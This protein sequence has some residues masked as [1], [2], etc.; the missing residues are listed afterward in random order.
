[1]VGCMMLQYDVHLGRM[2][3]ELETGHLWW[4][5]TVRPWRLPWEADSITTI[6]LFVLLCLSATKPLFPIPAESETSPTLSEFDSVQV[7]SVQDKSVSIRDRLDSMMHKSVDTDLINRD[8]AAIVPSSRQ[9]ARSDSSKQTKAVSN[10]EHPDLLSDRVS[11]PTP[12]TQKYVSPQPQA[13][14]LKP[15]P[16]HLKYAYLGDNQQFPVIIGNNHHRDQEEQLLEVLRKHKKAI[17]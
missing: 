16:E 5:T 4:T 11:Q 15:L 17:G 12:P 3:A 2:D 8:R 7:I 14:E 13:I 6:L 1:M 10:S 9:E